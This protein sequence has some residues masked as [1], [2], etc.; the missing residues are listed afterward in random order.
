VT[1]AILSSMRQMLRRP[2]VRCAVCLCLLFVGYFASA[3]S[4]IGL[5]FHPRVDS[6]AFN[7]QLREAT[8]LL[9][10]PVILIS[11]SRYCPKAIRHHLSWSIGEQRKRVFRHAMAVTTRGFR[12]NRTVQTSHPR[13][14]TPNLDRVVPRWSFWDWQ[15]HQLL[16]FGASLLKDAEELTFSKTDP[17]ARSPQMRRHGGFEFG[18]PWKISE[19]IPRDSHEGKRGQTEHLDEVPSEAQVGGSHSQDGVTAAPEQVFYNPI[20][21][22]F[23]CFD[24]RPD[25]ILTDHD[26]EQSVE[27]ASQKPSKVSVIDIRDEPD[28]SDASPRT[29]V[30]ATVYTFRVACPELLLDE[31]HIVQL[32]CSATASDK[33]EKARIFA[34]VRNRIVCQ[35]EFPR[36]DDQISLSSFSLA[37]IDNRTHL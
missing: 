35:K 27:D 12:V 15:N 1:T 28:L 6:L 18:E 36:R 16:S 17:A 10:K 13:I 3:G 30:Q 4:M 19:V 9:Y 21:A 23:Q 2:W 14:S 32:Q 33:D 7:K 34:D 31:S 11:K 20:D 29:R 37:S 22:K 24:N 26:G 25:L 5:A 8:F